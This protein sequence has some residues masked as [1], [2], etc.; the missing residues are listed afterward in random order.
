MRR[1]LLLSTAAGTALAAA[2]ATNDTLL[3]GAYRP[4]LYFGLRPRLPQSLMTGLLWFGTQDYKAF[5]EARH[6]CDQGDGMDTYTWTEYDPRQG[7]VEV[8]KDGKNNLDLRIEWLKVPGGDAGASWAVRVKGAPIDEKRPMRTSM[9]WYHGV[10]GLGSVELDSLTTH[11]GLEG[12][13]LFSGSTADLGDFDIRL[14]ED[15]GN[16]P[17][18]NGRFAQDYQAFF[19]KTQFL[20][21]PAKDIWKA[22]DLILGNIYETAEDVLKPFKDSEMGPPDPAFVLRLT[23]E[24]YSNA[25]FY[26]LQKFYEG[27]F[28]FDVYYENNKQHLDEKAISQGI[29]SFT[30]DFDRR[31]EAAFPTPPE[32]LAFSKA[33][34]S[35]L[36]GGIGYFYGTSIVDKAFVHEWDDDGL[37]GSE[38][39]EEDE[40]KKR[41]GQPKLT[42]P[43]A[44]LTATPSRS[45]FPRG[46]YWDEGFHLL[47][48]GAW[49]NDLSL[50]ILKDWFS[51]INADGW[52]AREQILGEE[53]RSRVPEEFQTQYP[54]Y[55]NPPT[56]AMAVT[57]FI[58][59]LNAA[60]PAGDDV[61]LEDL[62]MGNV[63]AQAPLTEA[64]GAP[65]TGTPSIYLSSRPHAIGYLREIYPALRRH[66]DWFRRT[67]R[68]QIRRYGRKA[69]SRT[70]AYR[71]RGRSETH[72][73]TSGMDD[74]PRA[75]PHAGELHLDLIS[76]MGFFTRTMKSIAAFLEETA[77]EA[78]FA[79][80][81]KGILDNIDDLHWSEERQQYCDVGINED[82]ESYLECNEGY[83]S[84]FPLLLGLLS[85]E[86]EHLGPMLDLMSDPEQLWS[87]FGLRSLSKSHALFGQGEN[88][89]R[90][91]IWMPM[92]Y[93]AL[94]SLYKVYLPQT[95]PHQ[96]RAREIYTRLRENIIKNVHKEYERTGYV[97][98]QYNPT[99][100]EGQRSH[101]FTGWTSLVT[102]IISEK[103]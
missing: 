62:G 84:L 43:R 97:W 8:I 38:D 47:H 91:P 74:Y 58:D 25:N 5:T 50:E 79:D 1:L 22:K 87:D 17:I 49:D 40:Q 65:T 52:V 35:N 86:S 78:E 24:V 82:D 95:G 29:K 21:Y 75:A 85:P 88:Y 64:P 31:F 96:Q 14:V 15:E 37:N 46:F 12:D 93:M 32:Y 2:S 99:T 59:R 83:L 101:P 90:G 28:Q 39:E 77:D 53:A 23:N 66:Y 19:G 33:V 44:L 80:I 34:T 89:W 27:P 3:W 55:A 98:E 13:I 26:A 7:G 54:T 9:I 76:W 103:Y 41:K 36:L 100:G 4:G 70:E 11:N 71:W 56:L 18:A 10:E 48:V 94:R 92:N 45:F 61:P 60:T 69:R 73:L 42:E 20:G 68:G 63:G 30:E 16:K 57:A 72:I 67:Q 81:E 51:L 102:L 6:A